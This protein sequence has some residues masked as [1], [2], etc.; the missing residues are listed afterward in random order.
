MEGSAADRH[1]YRGIA[2]LHVREVVSRTKAFVDVSVGR[3]AHHAGAPIDLRATVA[4]RRAE[5]RHRKERGFGEGVVRS[6]LRAL[7]LSRRDGPAS[8]LRARRSSASPSSKTTLTS[9]TWT[10][11]DKGAGL[12]RR[13][14]RTYAIAWDAASLGRQSFL[15]YRAWWCFTS[16][17][18]RAGGRRDLMAGAR[19]QF[20]RPA[21]RIHRLHGASRT[22]PS[23]VTRDLVRG[24]AR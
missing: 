8:V 14:M 18:G 12:P 9:V 24:G 11:G 15:L 7:L 16:A 6:R 19:C 20:F 10:P 2:Y 4:Q 1:L 3:Q 23:S 17:P 13:G 21:R 5:L 22:S